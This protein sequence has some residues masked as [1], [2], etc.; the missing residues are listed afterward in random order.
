MSLGDDYVSKLL[1]LDDI[2]RYPPNASLMVPFSDRN[3]LLSE[4][5]CNHALKWPYEKV[6]VSIQG[7]DGKG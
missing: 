7:Q 3:G 1:L 5:R 4:G 6:N 2:L